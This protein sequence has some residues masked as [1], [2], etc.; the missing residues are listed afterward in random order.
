[1]GSH[2]LQTGGGGGERGELCGLIQYA[3]PSLPGQL[4]TCVSIDIFTS[5]VKNSPFPIKNY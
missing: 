4:L 3:Q 1:M 2:Q 5:F